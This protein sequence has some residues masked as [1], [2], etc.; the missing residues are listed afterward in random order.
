[1]LYYL[2][3]LTDIGITFIIEINANFIFIYFTYLNVH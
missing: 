3:A 1:M 2:P